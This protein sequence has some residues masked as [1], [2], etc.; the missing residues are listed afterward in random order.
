MYLSRVEVQ[1]LEFYLLVMVIL[2]IPI[3]EMPRLRGKVP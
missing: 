3:M 1:L 2:M